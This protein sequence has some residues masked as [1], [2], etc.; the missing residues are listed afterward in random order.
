MPTFFP[1]KESLPEIKSLPLIKR[2][3]SLIDLWDMCGCNHL[4]SGHHFIPI[5]GQAGQ[6]D[7]ANCECKQFKAKEF[8]IEIQI[9]K[10]DI[11]KFENSDCGNEN[12]PQ[13]WI[14]Y[15]KWEKLNEKKDTR[16]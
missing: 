2:K 13:F 8:V 6:C 14:D 10:L 3:H 12:F 5:W 4:I 15:E 7:Y 1:M 16:L 11:F 9:R